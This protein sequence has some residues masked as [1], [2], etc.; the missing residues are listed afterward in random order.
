MAGYKRKRT[1][2]RLKFEDPEMDGLVVDTTGADIAE[3]VV[4]GELA[5]LATDLT[6]ANL[7]AAAAAML[8]VKALFASHLVAWNL[9]DDD[10]VPV[11]ATV[12]GVCTQDDDFILDLTTAWMEAVGGVSGPKEPTS[13]GGSPFPVASIPMEPLSPNPLSL[14]TPSLSSDVVSGSGAYQAS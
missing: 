3:F 1:I 12:E 9:E 13:N 2:Y 14:D 10:D 11:P 5:D 7:A 4:I 8:D 6:T